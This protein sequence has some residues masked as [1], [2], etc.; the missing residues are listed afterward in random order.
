VDAAG[1]PLADK[2]EVKRLS[3]LQAALRLTIRSGGVRCKHAES[4]RAE[5]DRGWDLLR[6]GLSHEQ[7]SAALSEELAKLT[8][9]QN[10]VQDRIIELQKEVLEA[11]EE[12]ELLDERISMFERKREEADRAH[13]GEVSEVGSAAGP[14]QELQTLKQMMAM[15]VAAVG[16]QAPNV[17]SG[18]PPDFYAALGSAPTGAPSAG[19]LTVPPQL[20]TGQQLMATPPTAVAPT[21]QALQAAQATATTVAAPVVGTTMQQGVA[22]GGLDGSSLSGIPTP[23]RRVAAVGAAAHRTGGSKGPAGLK[24]VRQGCMKGSR[25]QDEEKKSGP[26][27]RNEAMEAEDVSDED[28][29]ADQA[30]Q[31]QQ[32][33]TWAA[34]VTAQQQQQQQQYCAQQ[35]QQQEAAVLAQQQWAAQ[36]QQLL[37]AQQQ[38]YTAEWTAQQAA[39]QQQ[40]AA[41]A[42][43]QQQQVD[44]QQQSHQPGAQ[45]LQGANAPCPPPVGPATS[46]GSLGAPTAPHSQEAADAILAAA[47]ARAQQSEQAAPAGDPG[48][49]PI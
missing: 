40:A 7:R 32:A 1:M 14:R 45:E 46:S 39:Q 17:L 29:E 6:S 5:L 3:T 42:A 11:Q 28:L 13:H 10:V 30:A 24:A 35:S 16:T 36:Q 19:P 31:Q 33:V 2:A 20:V 4:I 23:Q 43:Q 49:G 25:R 22:H 26:H 41:W 18:L 38:Q 37:A 44:R 27:G 8:A 34:A 47:L 15:L 48:A 9:R 21:A 12:Q